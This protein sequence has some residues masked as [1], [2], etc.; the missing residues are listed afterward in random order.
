MAEITMAYIEAR[1]EGIDWLNSAKREYNAGVAILAKSGYKSIVSSKL[2]RL[3]ERPHTR[4]KLE[5]EIRQMIRVWYHPEDP[6]FEN[7]DLADD[8]IPGNDG[9][10]ETVSEATANGIVATA[11][12]ELS[13]EADEQ[14]AYPPV[15][16]KI[17]YDFR[18]CYNERSRQ[19]R[20]L[21]ELGETN[22]EAVCANRK[23]IVQHVG[24]LSKRMTLLAAIK[25]EYDENKSL[26]SDQQ[27]DE[28]YKNAGI[29]DEKQ[30]REDEETDIDSMSVE[31]LKKAKSNAKSK[32]SKAK[33]MLLYSSESRPKDGKENPLPPCPKRVRFERK[34]A[35]QEALVEKID[36]RLAELQ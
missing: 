21:S 24:I 18:E 22:T 19:H 26:P 8:A 32:I 23:D 20:L 33:N 11:E 15:I 4:E 35:N 12:Q 9:R 16:S 25:R 6:R 7:V 36:Y 28:L 13:R 34:V 31:E 30:E 1:R 10:A 5:Y 14:P 27:L 17:I 29:P 2:S 3:G